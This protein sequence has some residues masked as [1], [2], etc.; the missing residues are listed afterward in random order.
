MDETSQSP[1]Q[2]GRT[3]RLAAKA[4]GIVFGSVVLPALVSMGVAIYRADT[5]TQLA[6]IDKLATFANVFGLVA[7]GIVVTGGVAVKGL[8]AKAKE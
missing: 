7:V 3:Q 8:K 4:C 6:I 5:A 2:L 1:K